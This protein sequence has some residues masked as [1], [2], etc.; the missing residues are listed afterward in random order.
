MTTG[1]T[2]SLRDAPSSL[3]GA[4]LKAYGWLWKAARPCLAGHKRLRDGFAERLVPEGW[5]QPASVWVQAASGGEA[6]LAFTLL[7]QA[8]K[9]HAAGASVPELLLTSCTRQGYDVL[10][11]AAQWFAAETGLS[12]PQVRFFPLDEPALM[13]RALSQA[14]PRAVLLLET[15]LW[16]GLLQACRS[17]DVP[18]LVGNG[19]LTAKSLRHYKFLPQAWW[20]YLSPQRILAVSDVDAA[21]FAVLFGVERVKR[22][23]NLK[24]E[25]LPGVESPRGFESFK[26][27]AAPSATLEHFFPPEAATPIILFASTRKAELRPVTE[28]LLLARQA[29]PRAVLVLAPRH[30]H[31]APLWQKALAAEGCAVKLRSTA[32][33][34]FSSG[35]VVLWDAFGELGALYA[36]AQAVFI[37]GSLAPL[38][39]QNFLEALAQGVA[40]V[41]GPFWDNFAWAADFVA[42]S[43]PVATV[44]NAAQVAQYL[45]EQAD[46]VPDR[47]AVRQAFYMAVQRHRGGA[48]TLLAAVREVM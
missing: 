26:A 15:E 44:E 9:E 41:L 11:Q 12:A 40:P 29:A 47:N 10:Q 14:A 38:G 34:N 24:F 30:L 3:M 37:G 45:V 35:D 31:H 21:R 17:A 1:A 46:I 4:A 8:A 25:N 16:P 22:M 23:P 43:G 42:P 6:Y 36:R 13:R 18:V 19:R 7:R 27:Q 20:E 39:G 2:S 48:A 33:G 5:A 32:A 28:A